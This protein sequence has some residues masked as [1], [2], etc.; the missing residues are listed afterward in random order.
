M[1][2]L[3]DVASELARTVFDAE[4]KTG[5]ERI[6]EDVSK[7]LGD[8]STTLQETYLASIRYLR[9]QARAEGIVRDAY[10][11]A[12]AAAVKNDG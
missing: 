7:A 6:S 9:A 1:K 11:K 2:I 12:K 5:D 3:E 8:S 4:R 10:R